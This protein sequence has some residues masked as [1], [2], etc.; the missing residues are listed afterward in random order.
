MTSERFE[1]HEV[2][3]Q[4]PA[5][6]DMDLF[7]GDPALVEAVSREGADWAVPELERLGLKAGSARFPAGPRLRCRGG[8][9]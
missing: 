7:R 4:P 5:L 6:A 8:R 2:L 9:G 1:T 3:N